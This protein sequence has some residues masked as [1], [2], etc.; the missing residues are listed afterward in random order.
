MQALRWRKWQG[1]G[2]GQV[3]RLWPLA[4]TENI[5]ELGDL[6]GFRSDFLRIFGFG[7]DGVDYDADVDPTLGRE[8]A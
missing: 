4:T 7:F 3:K 2:A 1:R 8:I 6:E 5:A